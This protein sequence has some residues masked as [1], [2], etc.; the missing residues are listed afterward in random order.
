MSSRR[1]PAR[2]LALVAWFAALIAAT[3]PMGR[4]LRRPR[5][6]KA[7]DRVT[8]GVFVAFGAKLALS[9]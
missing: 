6:I 7:M 8:G 9:R 3:I 2:D 1:L 5:V 4:V